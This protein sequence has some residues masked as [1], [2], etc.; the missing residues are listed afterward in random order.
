MRTEAF[1]LVL[2]SQDTEDS[3]LKAADVMVAAP[4]AQKQSLITLREFG[5]FAAISLL[6]GALFFVF[7]LGLGVLFTLFP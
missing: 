6:G 2:L 1:D 3:E 5:Y 7:F 4:Q